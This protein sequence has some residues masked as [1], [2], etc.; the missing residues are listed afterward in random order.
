MS[1]EEE[2]ETSEKESEN[3]GLSE[4]DYC[5]IGTLATLRTPVCEFTGHGNAV[6]SADWIVGGDQICTASWDRTGAIWDV[7]TGEKIHSL[8]GMLNQ[9]HAYGTKDML[10]VNDCFYL[11]L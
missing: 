1:S 2:V 4:E 6:V 10:M 3:L 9:I 7:N 11:D 5:P 8:V